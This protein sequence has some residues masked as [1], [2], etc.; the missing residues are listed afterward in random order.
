M[1]KQNVCWLVIVTSKLQGPSDAP[2]KI[3]FYPAL[4]QTDPI[5]KDALLIS[6]EEK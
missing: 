1:P 2:A 4:G 3:V 5:I 6:S